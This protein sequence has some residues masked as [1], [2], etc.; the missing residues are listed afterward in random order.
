LFKENLEAVWFISSL[1]MMMEMIV[2]G[3]Y[4]LIEGRDT[5]STIVVLVLML[6]TPINVFQMNEDHITTIMS[7]VCMRSWSMLYVITHG[8]I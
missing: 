3:N 2:M 1:L 8:M 7:R 4:V 5:E 6:G